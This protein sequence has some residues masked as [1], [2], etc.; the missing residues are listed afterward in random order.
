M[1]L[2]PTKAVVLAICIS[3]L[4]T[5]AC[6]ASLYGFGQF[7][8]EEHYSLGIANPCNSSV[9]AG[10]HHESNLH[11]RQLVCDNAGYGLCPGPSPH[12]RY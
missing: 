7:P 8:L 12:K 5:A 9:N 3:F 6:E 10:Y 11:D 1:A 2:G 4:W